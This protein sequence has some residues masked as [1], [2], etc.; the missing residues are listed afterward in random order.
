MAATDMI[1][2]LAP[3]IARRLRDHAT[4]RGLDAADLARQWLAERLDRADV[5]HL[6]ENYATL[7]PEQRGRVAAIA[8]ADAS[9]AW[10]RALDAEDGGYDLGSSGP[11]GPSVAEGGGRS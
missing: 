9:A 7:S 5:D 2:T 6:I 8:E 1:V 11:P 3:S 10:L 4:R